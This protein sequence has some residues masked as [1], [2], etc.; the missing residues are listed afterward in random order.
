[1]G[2][3][4]KAQKQERFAEDG[5]FQITHTSITWSQCIARA[6]VYV[7]RRGMFGRGCGIVDQN[8]IIINLGWS[9]ML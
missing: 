1:M 7:A 8:N 6:C 3:Q 2:H 4:Q 9:L 5:H